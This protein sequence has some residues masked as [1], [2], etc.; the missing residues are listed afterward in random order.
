MRRLPAEWEVQSFVQFTF[1]H[2]HTDW[3]SSLNEV[4]KCFV[5][6]I[7][8]VSRFENVLVGCSNVEEV[9]AHFDQHNSIHFVKVESNDTWARDHGAITVVDAGSP[10]L[11]DFEFNGWGNKYKASSSLLERRPQVSSLST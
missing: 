5:E 2:A 4:T 6:I 1:P 8:T 7:E 9:K 10:L 3:A 11:L